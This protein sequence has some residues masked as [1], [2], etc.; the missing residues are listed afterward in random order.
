MGLKDLFRRWSKGEDDRALQR[1]DEESRMTPAERAVDSED[2]EGKKE[3]LAVFRI[4]SRR[5]GSR[6]PRP[7][8]ALAPETTES[9]R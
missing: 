6:R 4:G 5:C 2:F 3:D 1:A 9:G 8:A 7:A